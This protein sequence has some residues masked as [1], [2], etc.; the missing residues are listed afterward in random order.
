MLRRFCGS[1]ETSPGESIPKK[2]S[3]FGR[4]GKYDVQTQ[5]GATDD[6]VSFKKLDDPNVELH[7]NDYP[8]NCISEVARTISS[9]SSPT[10]DSNRSSVHETI[11][12]P[13]FVKRDRSMMN[14]EPQT[15]PDDMNVVHD[16]GIFAC[17]EALDYPP[18]HRDPASTP[19]VLHDFEFTKR[20]E[21]N[22]SDNNNGRPFVSIQLPAPRRVTND[23]TIVSIY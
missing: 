2:R 9:S 11:D 14:S 8:E 5:F 18:T 1:S 19:R 7:S 22:S 3:W 16:S 21:E 10:I 23:A 13:I 17:R 20:S 12:A 4:R 15:D 6:M